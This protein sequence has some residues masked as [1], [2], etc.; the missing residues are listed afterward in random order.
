MEDKATSVKVGVAN[1]NLNE[2]DHILHE[3]AYSTGPCILSIPDE[4]YGEIR[5]RP[6]QPEVSPR[7]V[8]YLFL[9]TTLGRHARVLGLLVPAAP[10]PPKSAHRSG[11]Q[12]DP[13]SQESYAGHGGAVA[14]AAAT[15]LYPSSEEPVPGD[16]K[17]GA[18]PTDREEAYLQDQALPADDLSWPAHPG[19]REGGFLPLHR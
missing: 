5:R 9:E 2:M 16:E 4:V 6:G 14:P 1:N 3:Q 18:I 8:V 7:P 11:A 15:G 10:Q 17:A 13:G 12:A 19:R